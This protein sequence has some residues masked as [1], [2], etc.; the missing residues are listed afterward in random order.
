MNFLIVEND[1]YNP[2]ALD[3]Y[4]NIGHIFTFIKYDPKLLSY[5]DLL[6]LFW[7]GHNP[8]QGNRQGN[9]IGSQYRSI[10]LVNRQKNFSESKKILL[11]VQKKFFEHQL[12]EIETEI[13]ILEKFY[14]AEDY[15][16]Q[17]LI[18]NPNGYCNLK[19]LN[20]SLE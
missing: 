10:I 1:N 12:G 5:P 4:I 8:T 19:N 15:H 16:Q 11:N 3:I 17:Y 18:R 14:Y 20:I 9:D 2:K 13:Q 7:E 6:K